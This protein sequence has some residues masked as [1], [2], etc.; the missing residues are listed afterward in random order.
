M[1][2]EKHCVTLQIEKSLALMTKDILKDYLERTQT[3]DRQIS[4]KQYIG[5]AVIYYEDNNDKD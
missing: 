4:P 1:D 5:N 2:K 3:S